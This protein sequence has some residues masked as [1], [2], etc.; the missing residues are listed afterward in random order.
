MISI[1]GIPSDK[2]S[3]FL[4]GSSKGPPPIMKEF[5]SESSN[6]FTESGINLDQN[7]IFKYNGCLMFK[8][9]N[10]EFDQIKKAVYD[11]LENNNRCISIGGDHSITYPIISAY[12]NFYKKLNILHFDAHP[13][14]YHNFDNNPFSHA[15]PFARIMENN[16]VKR[17]I[18]VGIRTMNTHQKEQAEKYNVQV[19]HMAQFD[20]TMQFDFDGP[21]YISIDLDALDPAFAPGVSHPEPGGLSTRDLLNALSKTN[22]EVVGGD[23]VEYNP[24]KDFQNT[25]A[26]TASKI[27][28]EL[29]SKMI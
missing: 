5:F 20:S 6:L 3:S 21:V 24:E 15:S 10:A 2:N 16:L 8:N 25:T 12:A 27:L 14:L 11:E 22:G 29:M 4:R 18:Q 7:S 1:I 19:I 9:Q 13:D 17:L 23:I 26:I 28:K